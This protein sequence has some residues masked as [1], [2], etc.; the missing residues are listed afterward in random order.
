MLEYCYLDPEEQTSNFNEILIEIHSFF[1]ENAFEN[2]IRK[3]AAIL[4]WLYCVKC[5]DQ[6]HVIT[7]NV[8]ICITRVN[9]QMYK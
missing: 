8:L 1:Q 4:S 5:K 9:K 2:A 7:Y 6:N 3:M